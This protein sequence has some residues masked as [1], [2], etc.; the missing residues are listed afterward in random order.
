MNT[1]QMRK[2][3]KELEKALDVYAKAEKIGLTKNQKLYKVVG[4]RFHIDMLT[5]NKYTSGGCGELVKMDVIHKR[6]YRV[7]DC[8][9]AEII[10]DMDNFGWREELSLEKLEII[11]VS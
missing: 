7:D 8:C 2:R 3:I 9:G 4:S 11:K 1:R 10:F 5:T 6:T